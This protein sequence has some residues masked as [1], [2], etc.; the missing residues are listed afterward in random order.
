MALFQ[1]FIFALD[2]GWAPMAC[3]FVVAVTVGTREA[4]HTRISPIS[5]EESGKLR[6]GWRNRRGAPKSAV[7]ADKSIQIRIT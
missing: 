2:A 7:C 1:D 5:L 6:P 4:P 3:L